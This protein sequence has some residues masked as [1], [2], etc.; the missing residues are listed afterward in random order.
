MVFRK[1]YVIIFVKIPPS[2]TETLLTENLLQKLL[3][4]YLGRQNVQQ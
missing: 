1:H 2:L 4:A 3:M